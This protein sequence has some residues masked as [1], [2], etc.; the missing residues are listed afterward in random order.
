[1]FVEAGPLGNGGEISVF[2]LGSSVNIIDLAKK[3]I[4][5]SGLTI[6]KDI[7]IKITGLRPGE[8]LYEELLANEENT[9]TTHHE[10][11]L[12]AKTS[13][14]ENMSEKIDKLI[15]LIDSQQNNKLVL[16][17]KSIIPEYLSQNSEYEELD[18]ND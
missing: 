12:I 3:M 10:K 17:L 13:V 4:S 6:N 1:I 11:I 2:A 9:I 14:K 8:K 7:E 16:L 15:D 5:L 18:K